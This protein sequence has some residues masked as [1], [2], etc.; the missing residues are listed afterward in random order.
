MAESNLLTSVD[1][2]WIRGINSLDDPCYLGAGF[3]QW[4][5][6]TLCTGGVY[7]TRP[8]YVKLPAFPQNKYPRGMAGFQPNNKDPQLVSSIGGIH[9]YLKYP[10]TGAWIQLP[11]LW[12]SDPSDSTVMFET[13]MKG[14]ITNADGTLSVLPNPYPV[15]MIQSG[16]GNP[17][18][19]TGTTFAQLDPSSNQTPIGTW[20]KWIGNRLWV[21]TGNKLRVSNILDPF[22]YTEEDLLAE[23]GYFTLPDECTGLAVT[24]DQQS[25]LAFTATTTTA[26]QAGIRERN[27]WSSTTNFQKVILP[28]IGCVSG[29]SIVSQYGILWWMSQGGLV[30]L[31]TALQAYRTSKVQYLDNRMARSKANLS[32]DVSRSCSGWYGNVL[33]IS[34]PSGDLYNAHT[35]VM[36]QDVMPEQSY[37]TWASNWKGV[38][39]VQYVTM[40]VKGKSRCFCLSQCKN[41]NPSLGLTKAQAWEVF[42]PLQGKDLG[43]VL[44]PIPSLLELKYLGS[45]AEQ[46][47]YKDYH[48][49][50]IELCGLAGLSHLDVFYAS[51]HSGYRQVLSK[52]IVATKESLV[53]GIEMKDVAT[54]LDQNRSVKAFGDDQAIASS[55]A[56]SK[57]GWSDVAFS[58]LLKW[59]GQLGVSRIDFNCTATEDHIESEE[60]EEF[61]RYIKPD[62]VG[63]ATSVTSFEHSLIHGRMSAPVLPNYPRI[64]EEEYS[65]L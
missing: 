47:V 13:A 42:C 59:T 11:L 43:T 28:N 57:L 27:T 1:G 16:I 23:G 30:R 39:P 17:L 40:N 50:Q 63:A 61:Q 65:A 6:N 56:E 10:F 7:K 18:Y 32:D 9:Y 29:N 62:G 60:D 15:L 4:S 3:V 55:E 46:E 22:T 45:R 51:R 26:F 5:E 41:N 44:K 25:L 31:D 35:W 64:E 34:V 21:A 36:D 12:S 37:P 19:W 52:D 58:V 2:G 8:S 33:M 54:Y 48:S 49:M 14:A 20:M 53:V 38:R 24:P